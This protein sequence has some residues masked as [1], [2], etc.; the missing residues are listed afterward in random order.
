[1]LGLP[2]NTEV[3]QQLP[4][5][6][7]YKKFKLNTAEKNA[8]DS[9][10]SKIII[11][12]EIYAENIN[13]SPSK[14]V[15]NFFVLHVTLKKRN[16]SEKNIIMLSNLISQDMLF[17]LEHE[18]I[19]KLATFNTKL[20]QTDWN[21]LDSLK[22][23]LNGLNIKQVWENIIIQIGNLTIEEGNSIEEQ[24]VVDEER[25]KLLKEISK[26]E[27]KARSER[28]P[29]RKYELFQKIKKLKKELES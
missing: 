13:V 12:N 10:I 17:I 24:I 19:A 22:I 1:M 27:K 21:K 4:K 18:G 28:Q 26:L 29:K 15:D 23:N 16:F 6:S 3:H 5:T 25:E 8:F 20:L 9:D 2:K 14:G 11:V 7:V